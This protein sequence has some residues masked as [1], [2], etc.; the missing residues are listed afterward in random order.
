MA[1]ACHHLVVGTSQLKVVVFIDGINSEHLH[2]TSKMSK[3]LIM[4]K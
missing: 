2:F 4:I 3:T 1:I